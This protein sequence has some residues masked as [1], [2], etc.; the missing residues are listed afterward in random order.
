[1]D[2]FGGGAVGDGG[3]AGGGRLQIF[4]VSRGGGV[5]RGPVEANDR[6]E[7]VATTATP[8]PLP[9]TMRSPGLFF[10]SSN[11]SCHSSSPD[12]ERPP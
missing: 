3:L 11:P 5:R 6:G 2:R 1:M 9:A 8:Q 4:I 12:H 7:P 10:P